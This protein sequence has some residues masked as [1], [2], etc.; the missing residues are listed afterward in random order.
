HTFTQL[1][2]DKNQYQLKLLSYFE[3]EGDREEVVDD[4]LLED[5]VW[6]RIRIAPES[7]PQGDVEIIPS[8]IFSRLRHTDIR[9]HKAQASLL[10][11]G[12]KDWISYQI[13]YPALK[14]QLTIHFSQSFPHEIQGWEESHSSGYGPNARTLTTKAKRKKSLMLDYWRH[15]SNEDLD[16]RADLGLE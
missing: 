7:L 16:K 15:N 10:V 5:E 3:S 1:N 9:P 8:T 4:V 2:H 13:N 11:D 6:N 12:E 14:R